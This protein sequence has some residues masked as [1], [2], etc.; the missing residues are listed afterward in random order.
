MEYTIGPLQLKINEH[1][2]EYKY[3]EIMVSMDLNQNISG[4]R[5]SGATY[6]D[7]DGITYNITSWHRPEIDMTEMF[8]NIMKEITPHSKL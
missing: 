6:Y 8:N 3:R 4:M 2:E 1:G 5:R 7:L